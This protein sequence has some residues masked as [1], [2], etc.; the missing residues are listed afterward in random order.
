MGKLWIYLERDDIVNDIGERNNMNKIE[1]EKM[2]VLERF[3]AIE[4]LWD[5]LL[6]E[7]EPEIESPEWHEDILKGGYD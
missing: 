5:S 3:Q 2:T 6:D 1:I 7:E 4:A